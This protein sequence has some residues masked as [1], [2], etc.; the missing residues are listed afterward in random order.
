MIQADIRALPQQDNSADRIAAVHVI[1]HFY[2][3]EVADVL[4]EWLRV[5]KPGGK[6]ILELPSLD[7]VFNHIFLRMKKGEAPAPF[8]S[9]LPLWGD[10]FYKRPEMTHKWGYFKADMPLILGRAGF[11]NIA[12]EEARYHFPARDMRFV[13]FKPEAA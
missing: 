11:V 4:K 12:E 3:W 1:E 10:P 7:R 2:Q 8:F 9:W 13:A 6:L 5:L